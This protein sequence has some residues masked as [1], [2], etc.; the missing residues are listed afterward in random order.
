MLSAAQQFMISYMQA[1]VAMIPITTLVIIIM[2]VA[3]TVAVS[4]AAA[5]VGVVAA[6][7]SRR[8]VTHIV[9]I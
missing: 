7:G 9:Y 5:A 2:L 8:P 3:V 1:V 6:T 4:A